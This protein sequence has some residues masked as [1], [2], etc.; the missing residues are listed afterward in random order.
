MASAVTTLDA[1]CKDHFFS[2]LG[3]LAGSTIYFACVNFFFFLSFFNDH[4]KNNYLR[5]IT[6]CMCALAAVMIGLNLIQIWWASDQYLQSSTVYNRR[7]S[8][9]R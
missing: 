2:S 1:D 5:N 3:K 4:S 7:R 6:M 9:I 8:A